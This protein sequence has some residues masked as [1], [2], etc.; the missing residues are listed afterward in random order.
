MAT[1]LVSVNVNDYLVKKQREAPKDTAN[2]W[3]Q[4]EELHNKK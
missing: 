4:L 3:A 2:D 1:P